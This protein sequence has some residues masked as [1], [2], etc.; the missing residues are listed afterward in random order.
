MDSTRT[1]ETTLVLWLLLVCC[2]RDVHLHLFPR[3]VVSE[4]G[5]TNQAAKSRHTIKK[6]AV[7][8]KLASHSLDQFSPQSDIWSCPIVVGTPSYSCNESKASTAFQHA[9]TAT[10]LSTTNGAPLWPLFRVSRAIWVIS[11]RSA[12]LLYAPSAILLGLPMPL[13][14][15]KFRLILGTAWSNL[16]GCIFGAQSR[17]W[18]LITAHFYNRPVSPTSRYEKRLCAFGVNPAWLVVVLVHTPDSTHSIR[19]SLA[20]E[21]VLHCKSHYSS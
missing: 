18:Y 5:K 20:S 21:L 17:H 7:Y 3:R 15:W 9:S 19:F 12:R 2:F 16:S 6:H 8:F 13:I 14:G 1:Q 11:G 4:H 10:A